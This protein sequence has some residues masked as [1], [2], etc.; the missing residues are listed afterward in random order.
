MWRVA[1]VGMALVACF[2][3]QLGDRPF[4]CAAGACPAGY[5][6]GADKLC[7]RGAGADAQVLGGVDGRTAILD[8]R[9]V[10]DAAPPVDARLAF[11]AQVDASMGAPTCKPSCG[12][13][14]CVGS[15]GRSPCGYPCGEC[16]ATV[17]AE[18]CI[19]H[20]GQMV[21][22]GQSGLRSCP[23]APGKFQTCVCGGGGPNAWTG[24]PAACVDEGC[25]PSTLVRIDP[26]PLVRNDP[27]GSGVSTL[28]YAWRDGAAIATMLH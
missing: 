19:D 17:I 2:D 14:S 13:S 12:P 18:P 3:P 20:Y 22:E 7:T 28:R 8:A 24:C 9:L 21:N 27:S 11:D 4:R 10:V 15:C 23:A 6:C 16:P 5:R 25:S 1:L 26:E